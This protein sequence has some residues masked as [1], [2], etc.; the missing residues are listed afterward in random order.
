M[1]APD[2]RPDDAISLRQWAGFMAMVV[3]MFMAVLDIQIVSASIT[4]IQAGL[5]ASPDEASWVQTSYLIAEIVMI[6]LSGWLSRRGLRHLCLKYGKLLPR[7]RLLRLRRDH[8]GIGLAGI[9]DR[10]VVGLARG[11]AAGNQRARA[12]RVRARPSLVGLRLDDRRLRHLDGGL[13]LS[14]LSLRGVDRGD[15]LGGGGFGLGQPRLPVG[16]VQLDQRI[17]GV[18]ALVVGH[19]DGGDVALDAGAEHGDVA[20]DI[21]V[22]GALD[23]AALG[24]PPRGA[25]PDRD[26]RRQPGRGTPQPAEARAQAAGETG[27]IGAALRGRGQGER[28]F[29]N[30]VHPRLL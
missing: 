23:V 27:R 21:G 8:R 28:L 22:V 25:D 20:L 16:G 18:H 14:D 24:E 2:A 29:G 3:G 26:D 4:D 11:P 5:A 9:G 10:L 7:G 1:S 15:G 12:R 17:A 19:L 13:L 30:S 6:P